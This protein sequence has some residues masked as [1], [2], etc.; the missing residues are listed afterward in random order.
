[1]QY[2]Q[3]HTLTGYELQV[4][5]KT[6]TAIVSP[7]RYFPVYTLAPYRLLCVLAGLFVAFVFTIFPVQISEHTIFR[8]NVGMSLEL[9]ARYSVSVSATLDQRIRGAEGDINQT[10][11][12]GAILKARRIEILFRELALL[13]Q[14]RQISTMVPWEVTIGGKF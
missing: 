8:K 9:L 1:M 3:A 5:V 11:S 14:M 6:S 12:P 4:S 7:Q 2:S 10:S 13:A